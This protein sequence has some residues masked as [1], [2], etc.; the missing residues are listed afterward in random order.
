M[1]RTF[2]TLL[3]L[4][5]CGGAIPAPE[6]PEPPPVASTSPEPRPPAWSSADDALSRQLRELLSRV[7]GTRPAPG[8]EIAELIAARA[9]RAHEIVIPAGACWTIVSATTSGMRDLDARLFEP[10]GELVAEDAAP[11]PRPVL[12]ACAGDAPRAL[13]LVLDAYDGAGAVLVGAIA[14][15]RDA[16]E[17]IAR[18]LGLEP[19]AS[20]DAGPR[21]EIEEALARRSMALTEAPLAVTLERGQA[22]RAPLR[23]RGGRCQAVLARARE[24]S[25]RIALR[26]LDV[27]GTPLTEGEGDGR[28]VVLQRCEETDVERAIEITA[29][30]GEGTVDLAIAEAQASEVGGAAALWLGRLPAG[31]ESARQTIGGRRTL[32]RGEATTERVR[33][34]RGCAR[35]IGRGGV[36]LSSEIEGARAISPSELEVCGARRAI[37]VIVVMRGGA[38]AYRI[39]VRAP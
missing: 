22:V 21:S 7:P 12:Q 2:A 32:A 33:V 31:G 14:S 4:A 8:L 25:L 35:V 1:R 9:Q 19:R 17:T 29:R 18:E 13:W 38:G 37:E 11:D 28:E 34:P 5:G 3:L 15:A 24:P 26:V 30:E 23:T 16:L 39:E 20:I 27:A 36:E 10:S 6:E